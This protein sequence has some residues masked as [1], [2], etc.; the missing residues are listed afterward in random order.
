[1]VSENLPDWVDQALIGQKCVFQSF[2]Y[3]DSLSVCPQLTLRP[4]HTQ[5][6]QSWLF[7]NR[8]LCSHGNSVVMMSCQLSDTCSWLKCK[9]RNAVR[10]SGY[11]FAWTRSLRPQEANWDRDKC[12]M[13]TLSWMLR[14]RVSNRN[15][16]QVAALPS[17]LWFSRECGM[18]KEYYL[19]VEMTSLR[20][21]V[22]NQKNNLSCSN[23]IV[24]FLRLQF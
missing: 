11:G 23:V 18:D 1:M 12:S 13:E 7:R 20:K 22:D 8:H 19:K 21:N 9:S 24:L 16:Y 14:G 6:P 3:P 2:D 17:V 4:C 10:M 5:P 15:P